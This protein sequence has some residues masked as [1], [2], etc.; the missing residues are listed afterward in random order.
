MLHSK[1]EAA[2]QNLQDFKVPGRWFAEAKQNLKSANQ[3]PLLVMTQAEGAAVGMVIGRVR[4]AK[5][6]GPGL[7]K[8]MYESMEKKLGVQL[9]TATNREGYVALL[10]ED[11]I[12]Q[13]KHVEEKPS[14]AGAREAF[15]TADATQEFKTKF[16]EMV[17]KKRTTTIENPI[18]PE[19]KPSN[20]GSGTGMS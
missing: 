1:A 10:D 14:R 15:K 13:D 19:E 9:A 8:R 2:L 5:L 11:E 16:N 12:K 20:T 3:E 18:I 7:L 17:E 6:E 4:D